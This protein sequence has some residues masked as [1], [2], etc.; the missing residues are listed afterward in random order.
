[1]TNFVETI[2]GRSPLTIA[3]PHSAIL[4]ELL[5][6]PSK[7]PPGIDGRMVVSLDELPDSVRENLMLGQRGL[8]RDTII[9]AA[10]VAAPDVADFF[11]QD[12]AT[13]IW[14]RFPRVMLDVNRELFD[15]P[16]DGL[17]EID[18]NSVEGHGPPAHANGVIWSRTADRSRTR[19]I[20][21]PLGTFLGLFTNCKPMIKRPYTQAEFDELCAVARDPYFAAIEAAQESNKARYGH[22]ITLGLHTFPA[23]TAG[24]I[25]RG[26]NKGAYQIGPMATR[27][28][29]F[30]LK[31][32]PSKAIPD[33]VVMCQAGWDGKGERSCHTRI[34]DIILKAFKNAGCI[35][36]VGETIFGSGGVP[37]ILG[38]PGKGHHVVDIELFGT[39]RG[40]DA[41]EP[42]R[43][44]GGLEINGAQVDK[45]RPIYNRI[46]RELATLETR[47]LR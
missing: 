4:Q 39:G 5:N 28:A 41:L 20:G 18:G 24:Y 38:K 22:S 6:D 10:D 9:G 45:L 29:P 27:R 2:G 32:I 23:A 14:T 36:H 33:A 34:T 31:K 25:M 46:I 15:N 19:H 47:D 43:T 35:A 11:H 44:K 16:E 12:R 17:K 40:K 3:A 30:E 13:R 26:P 8:V 42:M 1:M 21:L 37:K 7:L